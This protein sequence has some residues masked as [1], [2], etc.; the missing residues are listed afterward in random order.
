MK[1]YLRCLMFCLNFIFIPNISYSHEPGPN[2]LK[3]MALLAEGA[4]SFLGHGGGLRFEYAFSPYI[5]LIIPL[6]Y[7]SVSMSMF[8]ESSKYK[9]GTA[10]VGAK[11]YFS[12]LFWTQSMLRGFFLDAKFGAGYAH[13]SGGHPTVLDNNGAT[14]VL[15]AGLGYNH[16]F[17]FGL[18]LSASVNMSGRS[19]LE[20]IKA[21]LFVLDPL[22]ELALGL[23]W[24]W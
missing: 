21:P 8:D 4:Y 23:G 1:N 9:I 14:F 5:S 12:Q 17:D 19:H 7:R 24:A 20:P 11:F 22:P 16:A 6:E 15:S 10:G 2:S 3:T 18:M 13:Q